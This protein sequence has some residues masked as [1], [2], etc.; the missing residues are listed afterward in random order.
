MISAQVGAD[1]GEHAIQ[2]ASMR[3]YL[4]QSIAPKGL[5]RYTGE[6]DQFLDVYQWTQWFSLQRRYGTNLL[7]LPTNPT[8]SFRNQNSQCVHCR[9]GEQID[10]E[11]SRP[12]S[13]TCIV[14]HIAVKFPRKKFPTILRSEDVLGVL[15]Y[16]SLAANAQQ[17]DIQV[18]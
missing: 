1:I 12:A 7:R 5:Q 6:E 16:E 2:L 3:V 14:V 10:E 8:R 13:K 9:E 4:T 15:L 11:S 17:K 18:V